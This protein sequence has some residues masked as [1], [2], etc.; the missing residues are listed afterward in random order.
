MC[1]SNPHFETRHLSNG[2]R[3]RWVHDENHETR[4]SYGLDTEEETK[5]AEDEELAKLASGE[6]VV[7]GCIVE[8]RKACGEFHETDSLWGIV[9]EPDGEKLDSFARWHFGD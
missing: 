5:A 7:L 6:W 1:R 8:E 3:C 9:I 4:G 2:K